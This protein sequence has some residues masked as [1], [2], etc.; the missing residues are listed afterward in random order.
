MRGR[1]DG[2]GAGGARADGGSVGVFLT[3]SSQK[4][5]IFI[6]TVSSRRAAARSCRSSFCLPMATVMLLRVGAQGADC[7]ERRNVTLAVTVSRPYGYSWDVHAPT[8]TY[9]RTIWAYYLH[10]AQAASVSDYYRI[11]PEG[12]GARGKLR[13][14]REIV[15]FPES[16]NV[17]ARERGC[18]SRHVENYMQIEIESLLTRQFDWYF[19]WSWSSFV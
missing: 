1:W 8:K 13:R 10:N 16:R 18:L 5:G 7:Y 12:Y 6:E 17:R 4:V 19:T 11:S 14:K 15:L 9:V 2:E 3:R